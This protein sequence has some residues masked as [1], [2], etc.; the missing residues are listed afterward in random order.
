MINVTK[1]AAEWFKQE[2]DLQEGQ[3]IRFFPRYSSGGGVHPG[4]SLG[5]E[6]NV[7]V[8]ASP[9]L[10]T[11]AGGIQFYMEERDLWYL[12]G[13]HFNITYNV[14]ASDIEYEY[15]AARS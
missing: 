13:Y 7:N 12:Q 14:N 4:F 10:M 11:E 15:E 5:I 8:P 6:V 9:G 3:A 1:E 2:L